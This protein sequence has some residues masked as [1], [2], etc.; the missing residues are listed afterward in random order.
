MLRASKRKKLKEENI[1]RLTDEYTKYFTER[2]SFEFVRRLGVGT[3]A[4]ALLFK[5]SECEASGTEE[6]NVAVKFAFS[7]YEHRNEQ[8]DDEIE[9]ERK[10]LTRL[11]GAEHI[12][13]ILSH[14]VDRSKV[15][16]PALV[17]EYVQYGSIQDLCKRLKAGNIR[18]PNR[19]L[20][21]MFLCLTRACI[22]FAYPPWQ[23]DE[24]E[25]IPINGIKE[26]SSIIHND[27]HD[28]NVLISD[29]RP[30]SIEHRHVP[31]LKAIDFGKATI[32]P[33]GNWETADQKNIQ[34]A[35]RLITGVVAMKYST[36]G[37]ENMEVDIPDKTGNL[38]KIIVFTDPALHD[39]PYLLPS[40]KN[41]LLLCQAA[42]PNDRPSL[43]YVLN[44]CE[45][46][47]TTH[48]AQT[49]AGIANYDGASETD[50]SIRSMI[51]QIV[52]NADSSP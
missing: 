41:I 23:N 29:L 7:E 14:D 43:Q 48:T 46:A 24:Q 34:E 32:V 40:L 52:F 38:R 47:V 26:L 10:W 49:Y 15:S 51:Q 11:Q 45:K 25:S 50:D 3:G 16:R 5:E 19:V 27:L 22:G 21:T 4:A 1:Q 44:T 6:R 17:L 30:D 2:H 8:A 31:I 9:N 28:E 42:N 36:L 12:V 18:V 35:A 13:K 37:D 39:S 33:A 20:W